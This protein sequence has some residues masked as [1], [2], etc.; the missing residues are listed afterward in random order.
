MRSKAPFRAT[1]H[2]SAVTSVASICRSSALSCGEEGL[3]SGSASTM[4]EGSSAGGLSPV[5]FSVSAG[6]R[7]S[8]SG[9]SSP[10][11][12]LASEG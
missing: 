11:N 12:S 3:V 1:R 10:L 9:S 7:R 6:I 4:S 2:A 8:S 5:V